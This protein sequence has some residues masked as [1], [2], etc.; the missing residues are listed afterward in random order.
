MPTNYSNI[1]RNQGRLKE[2]PQIE[3]K[4]EMYLAKY[5]KLKYILQFPTPLKE[6]WLYLLTK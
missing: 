4:A 1:I 5:T 3:G 2:G 6:L